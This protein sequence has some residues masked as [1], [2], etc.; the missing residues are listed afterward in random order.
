MFNILDLG[1]LKKH[2]GEWYES[3]S[4][5]NGE[6]YILTSMTKLE[7]EVGKNVKEKET[8][9]YPNKNLRKNQGEPVKIT[10]YRFLV[11]KVLYLMAKLVPDLAY[12]LDSWHNICQIQERNSG[13]QLNDWLYILRQYSMLG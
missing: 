6:T 10:E 2:H 12:P 5:K 3:K 1:R 11:G 9:L 8:P 13:K 4:D 7:D